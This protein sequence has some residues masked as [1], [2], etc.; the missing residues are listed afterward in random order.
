MITPEKARW[1]L[2]DYISG[3]CRQTSYLHCISINH[4][5][6]ALP[7]DESQGWR[8]IIKVIT[9]R[10]PDEGKETG[11]QLRGLTMEEMRRRLG[12]P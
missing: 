11:L 4:A 10:L 9:S 6:K 5:L 1:I 8:E 12:L 7:E 2:H 3:G